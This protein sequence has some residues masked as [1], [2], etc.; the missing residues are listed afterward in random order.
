ML[1]SNSSITY[2]QTCIQ[3]V[4]SDTVTLLVIQWALIHYSMQICL[5][6]TASNVRESIID[7]Q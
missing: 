6:E 5:M 2:Q 1:E 4:K 3:F 7:R